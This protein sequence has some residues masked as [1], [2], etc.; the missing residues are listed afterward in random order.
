MSAWIRQTLDVAGR[1]QGVGFRPTLHRA[2]VR[3][4]LGG[5]IQ[6]RTSVVRMSLEGPPDAV[7]R[8][9]RDLPSNAP[10]LARIDCVFPGPT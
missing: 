4:G 2:A 6:N 5:W 9:I 1:V 10:P 3:A 8:F 7:R